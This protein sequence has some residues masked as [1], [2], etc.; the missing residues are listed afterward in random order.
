[1]VIHSAGPLPLVS[2]SAPAKAGETLVMWA[3]GLGAIEHPIPA[4][5]C[6]TPDQLPLATQPFNF[7]F[8][9]ADTAGGAFHRLTQTVP[10]YAGMVGE[11]VY[12]VHFAVPAL[13][14]G[15]P[16]CAAG[17]GNLR[18]LVSG[19]GSSDGVDLCVAQ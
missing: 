3:Y 17:K 7:T 1:M 6:S 4:S 16:A 13:P 14:S 10:S 9:Y 12:Q 18:V 5:C 11:G 15:L 19:P 2:A 8:S